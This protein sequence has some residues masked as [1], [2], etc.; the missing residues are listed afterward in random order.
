MQYSESV[1]AFGILIWNFL[2]VCKES[3]KLLQSY[4][5]QKNQLY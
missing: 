1:E 3:V 2:D 5:H 4:I